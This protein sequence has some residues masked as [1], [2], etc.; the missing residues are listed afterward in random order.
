MTKNDFATSPPATGGDAELAADL[1]T[2]AAATRTGDGASQPEI[3]RH[4]RSALGHSHADVRVSAVAALSHLGSLT[5]SDL[6]GLLDD[7]S[8]VVRRRAVEAAV[9]MIQ[10]GHDDDSLV[11]TLI[12]ALG[13]DPSV[14][15]VAA[16]A[17]GEF[18]SDSEAAAPAL[19]ALERVAIDHPDA[20]CRESAVAALGA[21]HQ[22]LPTVLRAMTD[23]ATVRRRAVLA[24]A[25]FEGPEVDAA[26]A[27]AVNDR[28]WQVRQAAEDQVAARS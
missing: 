23:K 18:G 24:L 6:A 26:L 16:F 1:V 15:E 17:L 22:G 27:H 25:P 14:T 7:H 11:P 8:A 4:A 21:L 2:D 19:V 28:D 12:R 10:A 5:A 20:L 9:T 13:D 3:E